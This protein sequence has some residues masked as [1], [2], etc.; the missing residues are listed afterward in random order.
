MNMSHLHVSPEKCRCKALI[1]WDM[2][3][4]TGFETPKNK[5]L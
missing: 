1:L 4:G 2:V 5:S 3:G